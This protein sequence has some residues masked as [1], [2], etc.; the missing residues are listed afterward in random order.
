GGS[1]GS[2]GDATFTTSACQTLG[3]PISD[4]FDSTTLNTNLWTF[5]NPLGD[6][7]VSLS[8]TSVLLS[9]PFGQSHDVWTGGNNSARIMQSIANVDFDIE[10]KFRST[11]IAQY[12]DQGLIVEQDS[13]TYIRLDILEADCQAAVFAATFSGGNPTVQL[14]SRIRNGAANY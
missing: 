6:A 8:G 3:P 4:N 11:G 12:Q 13:L 14:N 10:V 7:S 5:V 2:S 9:V 1:S